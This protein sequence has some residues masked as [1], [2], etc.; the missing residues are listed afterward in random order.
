MGH[1][2]ECDWDRGANGEGEGV[3]LFTIYGKCDIM[4]RFGW[5]RA[6]GKE[7]ICR[8]VHLFCAHLRAIYGVALLNSGPTK[9]ELQSMEEQYR[10][11]GFVGVTW[12]SRLYVIRWRNF[13]LSHHEKYKN[14]NMDLWRRWGWI[15]GVI[16]IS[17][18]GVGHGELQET[19]T[20]CLWSSNLSLLI[21]YLTH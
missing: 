7:T 12:R 17:I 19:N 11:A 4:T 2:E 18:P 13:I 10:G 1:E 16:A 5:Q 14:S 20:E 6:H 21:Y 3:S 8:Y 9:N 15:I